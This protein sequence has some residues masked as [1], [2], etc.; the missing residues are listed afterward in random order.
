MRQLTLL[1]YFLNDLSYAD[2]LVKVGESFTPIIRTQG[3]NAADWPGLKQDSLF[4]VDYG[5][6]SGP[7]F[8]ARLDPYDSESNLNQALTYAL[9]GKFD[10]IGSQKSKQIYRGGDPENNGLFE[11]AGLDLPFPQI[12]AGDILDNILASLNLSWLPWYVWAA[13]GG[14][15]ILSAA[16]AKSKPFKII[17]GLSG[18]YLAFRALKKYRS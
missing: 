5:N 17:Y 15:L 14:V 7:K 10:N 8:L 3:L 16:T 9:A 11:G 2:K 4:I 13:A 6:P 12:G 18:G 1:Y